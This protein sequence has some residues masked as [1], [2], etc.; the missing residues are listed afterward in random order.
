MY[1]KPNNKPFINKIEKA[2]YDT[3][4]AI[5][6]YVLQLI[7]TNNL[8]YVFR[9]LLNILHYYCRTDTFKNSF[10]ANVI[11]KWNNEIEN[12]R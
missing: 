3:A 1:D 12:K 2:P 7:P 10:F 8:S 9:K 4:L 11:N 5:T 6:K